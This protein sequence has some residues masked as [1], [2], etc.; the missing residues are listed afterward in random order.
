M[1]LVYT[2]LRGTL[3]PTTLEEIFIHSLCV[4]SAA[5]LQVIAQD[6]AAEWKVVFKT[7]TGHM[8]T[9]FSP[10]VAYTEATAAQVLDP[11]APQ[12]SAAFHVPITGCNGEATSVM[13]PSQNALAVSL[14]GGLRPNG[15]PYKGRFYLPPPAAGV[16]DLVGTGTITIADRDNIGGAIGVFLDTLS[17]KGHY[18][19]IWSRKGDEMDS[20]VS[21]MRVGNKIDTIRRRRNKHPE[22]YFSRPVVGPQ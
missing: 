15:S 4:T 7:M 16:L 3:N 13:L 1:A 21:T 19:T 8:A 9:R 6:V 14:T 10:E 5:S 11:T 12:L 20:L 18:P 2:T 17:A 22:L